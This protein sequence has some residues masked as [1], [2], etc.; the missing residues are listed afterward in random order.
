[1]K[2]ILYLVNFLNYYGLYFDLK[3][4]RTNYI[5]VRFFQIFSTLL[6]GSGKSVASTLQFP[7]FVLGSCVYPTKSLNLKLSKLFLLTFSFPL[8]S[9]NVICISFGAS[10]VICCSIDS[11]GNECFKAMSNSL[12]FWVLLN[13]LQSRSFKICVISVL[14]SFLRSMFSD[15]PLLLIFPAL[16]PVVELKPI[17]YVIQCYEISLNVS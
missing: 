10:S 11:L 15:L 2:K 6:I 1:M 14:R 7:L 5:R 8:L 16:L 17:I 12:S 9:T 13:V 4:S 3:I